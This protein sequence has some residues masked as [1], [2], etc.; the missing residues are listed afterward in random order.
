M[1]EDIEEIIEVPENVDASLDGA[2]SIKGPKGE[3]KRE[4]QIPVELNGKKIRLFAKRGT[5]N[6]KK[7]I[8]TTKAHINNMIKGVLEG[9]NYVLQIVFVHFPMTLRV[10]KKTM[11]IKNFLGESKERKANL[12]E[13]VEVKIEGDKI[14][15]FSPD[16]EAAGQ[17]AANIETAT[18]ITNRDRRIFQDG[19]WIIETPGKKYL[20]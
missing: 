8:M 19:I 9:Y 3:V 7:L 14:K 2:L 18:R 20:E 1:H 4:F 5:R 13:N 17:T 11:F 12:Y 6:Q 15:I 16:K 10:E